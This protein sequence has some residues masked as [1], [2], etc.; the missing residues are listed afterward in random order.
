ME[1]R[2]TVCGFF[3]FV[4]FCLY[5]FL[6]GGHT[7][8]HA[9]EN[10][11]ITPEYSI[12]VSDVEGGEEEDEAEKESPALTPVPETEPEQEEVLEAPDD[13][14]LG[15]SDI[16]KTPAETIGSSHPTLGISSTEGEASPTDYS[17]FIPMGIAFVICYMFCRWLY[18]MLLDVI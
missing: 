12:G 8:V 16:E 2:Q 6:L 5:V 3:V 17:R 4:S 7:V 1:P 18:H 14:T 10:D 13:I 9:S 11:T 15:T